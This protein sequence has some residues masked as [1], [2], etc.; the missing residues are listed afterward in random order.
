M[1]YK[2]IKEAIEKF[3]EP[4]TMQYDRHSRAEYITEQK[5]I[6]ILKKDCMEYVHANPIP[7]VFRG[8]PGSSDR[9]Y[10]IIDPKQSTRISRNTSNYYTWIIDNSPRWKQF[11][12]RSNSLICT[13]DYW[14]ARNYGRTYMVMPIDGAKFGVCPDSDIWSSF[15]MG[16]HKFDMDGDWVNYINK[17]ILECFEILVQ[18]NVIEEKTLHSPVLHK[19]TQNAAVESSQE[20]FNLLNILDQ[21]L[22]NYR[23]N[24]PK[25]PTISLFK[26]KVQKH[27][28]FNLLLKQNVK[29]MGVRTLLEEILDPKINN[30]KLAN[31]T[32]IK[33]FMNMDSHYL[34]EVWTDS[35]SVL[36]MANDKDHQAQY[37]EIRDKVLS[38]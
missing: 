17:Q 10:K 25:M 5:V 21:G 3:R 29:G 13:G 7:V 15:A 6:E 31:N 19:L 2:H 35:I 12:K 22:S 16:Q 14:K 28:M 24:T 27:F 34:P 20:F 18:A 33:T 38:T 1:R 9:G 23:K 37:K 36:V 11:P 32:T 4:T 26:S 8:A 30:F